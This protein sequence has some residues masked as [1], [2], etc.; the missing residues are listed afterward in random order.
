VNVILPIF[1]GTGGN[2]KSTF[3]E[4]VSAA[5]GDYAM[6]ADPQ[7]LM[8]TNHESHPTGM[9][10]LQSRR[11]AICMETAQNRRLDAPT[12]KMLTGGDTITARYMR[13][14]FFSFEPSHTILM[15]T[16]HKP[17]VDG[18]D[19][20]LWR[21][22]VVVPFEQTFAGDQVQPDLKALLESEPDAILSWMIEGWVAYKEHGL[23][24]PNGVRVATE[25]Y[26][27]DSDAVGRFIGERFYPTQFGTAASAELFAAWQ[28]WCVTNGEEPVT[29]KAFSE[30]LTRRGYQKAKT[31]HGAMW[32]GFTLLAEGDEPDKI[33]DS[34]PRY[35]VER[36]QDQTSLISGNA[37]RVTGGDGSPVLT[38]GRAHVA[39][40]TEHPSPPVT[41]ITWPPG[42]VGENP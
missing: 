27:T 24:I 33:V 38:H 7:L 31:K 5:L 13:Q 39:A 15:I 28:K 16:N 42:S 26:K 34:E 1:T 19:D 23:A 12:A 29:Q 4:A 22:L 36:E 32:K 9:A 18:S 41:K 14:D 40:H 8:T 21:R 20:A 37:K 3:T 30:E 11:L 35:E 17:V 2:G 10:A 25:A 6:Q